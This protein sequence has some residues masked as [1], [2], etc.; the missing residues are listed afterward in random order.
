MADSGKWSRGL[1]L[2]VDDRLLHGQV[3]YGWGINGPIHKMWLINDRVAFSPKE[4]ELYESSLPKEFHGG[5]MGLLEAVLA[6]KA[7]S[8]EECTL[9]VVESVKDLHFLIQEGLRPIA[10]HLGAIERAGDRLPVTEIVAL[11]SEEKN[12]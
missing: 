7:H 8:P 10:I 2:R 12:I 6:W 9:G 4:R 3:V 11:S 5:T 1:I